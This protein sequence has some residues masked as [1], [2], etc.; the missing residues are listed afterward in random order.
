MEEIPAN[1]KALNLYW[2]FMSTDI[3]A[4]LPKKKEGQQIWG[5][6]L[7]QKVKY[8]NLQIAYSLFT[9][10]G[11]RS[12]KVLASW[13]VRAIDT[14]LCLMND[15]SKPYR[16]HFWSKANIMILKI[17]LHLKIKPKSIWKLFRN[18]RAKLYQTKGHWIE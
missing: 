11:D 18:Y 15:Y 5:D 4:Y 7:W 1:F 17:I 13:V 6:F 10:M 12:K 8:L 3:L 14:V 2:L 9:N 16:R